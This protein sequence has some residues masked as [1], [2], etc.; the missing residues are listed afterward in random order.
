MYLLPAID[1]LD[2]RAVRLAKGDY[3]AVTV[4]NENPALQAQ[5][6][7][8]DGA[9]WL[10]VVDLN[11]AKSGN[12]DNVEVI[13]EILAATS[14][15]VEV[16]GGVRSLEAAERLLDA[17]ATR[18]ILG[19][20]LVRD[21]EFAQAAMEKF[22]P[23]ALVAG[24]D[25]KAG[26]AAVAGWTEGSGV[27]ATDLA[28]SM[29]KLGYA[30][31]VYTDIA[32]DGMQTGVENDAYAK[33]AAAFGNPVIVSGGIATAE[34]ILALAPIADAVEGVITGRAIYEGTLSVA[35]GVAACNGTYQGSDHLE[36]E[37][38][39]LTIEDLEF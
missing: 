6:F 11:G 29:A 20:A 39:P 18:V 32:R 25:A 24:I 28:A 12:P 9:E 23:D 21:P 2:G 13:R 27:A 30:H 4:Y 5:L 22:G 35:D 19:T 34:N 36:E 15:K 10:H 1:I 37:E 17:G 16:G 14:L 33:M 38:R 26:E 3:R 7:E 8:E 31:I